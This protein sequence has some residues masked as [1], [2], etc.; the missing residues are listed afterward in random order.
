MR[1]RLRTRRWRGRGGAGQTQKSWPA[2]RDV[3]AKIRSAS[4]SSARTPKPT[5]SDLLRRRVEEHDRRERGAG[6][7]EP[8]GLALVGHG[9]GPALEGFARHRDREHVEAV[10]ERERTEQRAEHPAAGAGGVAQVDQPV[11]LP[12]LASAASRAARRSSDQSCFAS[13]PTGRRSV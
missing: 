3:S 10:A 8:F 6:K 4:W 12:E 11:A 13:A 5:G 1:A 2:S 7:T 9:L